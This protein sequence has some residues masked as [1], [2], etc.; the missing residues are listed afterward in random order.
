[1]SGGEGLVS[2][3]TIFSSAASAAIL[4]PAEINS[5]AT[6]SDTL[7][8]VIRIVPIIWDRPCGCALEDERAIGMRR[9][10]RE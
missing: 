1:M 2:N 4:P 3:F 8:C 5:R 9:N 6:A 7:D 10:W